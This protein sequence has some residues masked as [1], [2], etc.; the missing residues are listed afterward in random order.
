M[1][2]GFIYAML[3]TDA[4]LTARTCMFSASIITALLAIH[5]RVQYSC[6]QKYKITSALKA[7]FPIVLDSFMFAIILTG[8][9]PGFWKAG[10]GSEW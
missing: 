4:I 9:G 10:G 5:K 2:G 6:F 7:F 8:A 1:S 3:P